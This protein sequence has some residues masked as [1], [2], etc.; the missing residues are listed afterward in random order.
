MITLVVC[1]VPLT[2]AQSAI[3]RMARSLAGR[4]TIMWIVVRRHHHRSA[5]RSRW[6]LSLALSYCGFFFIF[7]GG[8][9]KKIKKT[10]FPRM[11][12]DLW[13]PPRGNPGTEFPESTINAPS[14]TTQ[15]VI[16]GWKNYR[17]HITFLAS[18]CRPTGCVIRSTLGC[19]YAR[20]EACH[21][22]GYG[23]ESV[24]IRLT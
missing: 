19:K 13:T 17:H 22:V 3:H 7:A 21:S 12:V 6:H 4:H 5:V 18:R 16:G 15:P 8:E 23:F 9:N 2:E 1:A 11:R 14:T 20:F 24:D 10:A